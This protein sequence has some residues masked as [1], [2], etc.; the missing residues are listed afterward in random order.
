MLAAAFALFAISIV[1]MLGEHTSIYPPIFHLLPHFLQGSMY[2]ECALLGFSMFAAIIAALT[3]SQFARRIPATLFALLIVV[4]SWNLMKI[5]ANRTFNTADDSWK[6]ATQGW[7]DG[8]Y[9]VFETIANWTRVTN[10][11]LR[12]DFLDHDE[13]DLRSRAEITRMATA[14]GDN[15]FM[16]L[17]YYY[18]RLTF[19]GDVPWSRLQLLHGLDS[20]W[21][22][23]LNVGYVFENGSASK[24]AV[25]AGSDVEQLPFQWLRGYRITDPL[26]RFYLAKQIHVVPNE[27]A[28]L[29]LVKKAGFNPLNE[30]VVEGLDSH[31][32][33]EGGGPIP[34]RVVDYENNRVELQVNSPEPSFLVTSETLYP[35]WKA[36]VNGHEAPILPTNVAFR[37]VA[38]EAGENRI[39]MSYFP[40]LLVVGL[41]ISI[42]SSA[43]TITMLAGG[44]RRIA[45]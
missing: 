24:R 3:L 30:T 38:L 13:L 22:R 42:L 8:G 29:N 7:V 33:G 17:R 45:T 34:V 31:W 6:V 14:G 18:L 12:T 25:S 23:A 26:P 35:G 10:P 36:T 28:A 37:G 15:P 40:T 11:P 16:P 2:A 9:P 43:V 44:L 32:T 39:V 27:T 1:W 5:G 20:P 4:N 21:I 19:S 41:V